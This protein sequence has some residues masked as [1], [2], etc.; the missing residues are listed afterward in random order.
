MILSEKNASVKRISPADAHYFYGYYDN[1][2]MEITDKIHLAH[3]VEFM[4]RLPNKNDV[5]QLGYI[6]LDTNKFVCF[7]TTEAWNFQQG[8]MLQFLPGSNGKK[9][10]YNVF[11]DGNY[12]SVVRNLESGDVRYLD[13]PVAN[14]APNGKYALSINFSRLFDF[15][16]GYGY[17]NIP[18]PFYYKNHCADDGVFIV[19]IESGKSRLIISY[20]QL[21]DFTKDYFKGKDEKM[22]INHIT[23]NT[24]SERFIILLRNFPA[25]GAKHVT[26]LVTADKDGKDMFLLSDYGI[27]SHYNWLDGEY[28]QFFSDGKELPCTSGWANNYLLKD[29]TYEG[30]LIADNFFVNDDNHMNYS[31]DRKFFITDSYPKQERM[32]YLR[33]YNIEKD[34]CMNLGRFYSMK[35]SIIDIRCDLH[36]RWN[37]AGTAVTFDSTH[38]GFRGIYRVELSDYLG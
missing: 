36:P 4:D 18:D 34:E 11:A 20:E 26:A 28:I 15:R 21:W 25:P 38:E 2:A 33:L 29:K 30:T 5:A 12:A 23:F 17:C 27:Q 35:P 32:Q 1:P 10:I 16:P 8:A 3:R 37:C 7:D 13:R 24:T 19:D 22:V 14:V 31:P 6:E 9:V